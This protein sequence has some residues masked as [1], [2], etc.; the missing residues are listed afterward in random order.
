MWRLDGAALGPDAS[1]VPVN[2]SLYGGETDACAG[3]VMRGVQ[4]LE[5]SEQFFGVL[6]CEASAVVGVGLAHG[7]A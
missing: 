5:G 4:T 2:D 1:A 7:T 6:H 3:E